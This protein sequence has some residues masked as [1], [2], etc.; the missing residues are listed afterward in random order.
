MEITDYHGGIRFK[1]IEV[2][3]GKY[4]SNFDTSISPNQLILKTFQEI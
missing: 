1:E 2:L 4:V 3:E